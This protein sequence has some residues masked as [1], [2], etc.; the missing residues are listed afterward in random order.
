MQAH[1]LISIEGKLAGLT[2][3]VGEGSEVE[4]MDNPLQRESADVERERAMS[5][6]SVLMRGRFSST[7]L[8]SEF[9]DFM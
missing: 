4:F 9:L 2:G 3:E 5:R 7:K 6:A 1:E 8:T